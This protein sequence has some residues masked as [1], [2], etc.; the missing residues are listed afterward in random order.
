MNHAK[1]KDGR[2][3]AKM[4]HVMP[5][6]GW[7]KAGTP[8]GNKALHYS[9]L[10]YLGTQRDIRQPKREVLV[11]LGGNMER[12]LWTINGKKFS[13]SNPVHLKYGERVRL[14][15]VNNTMMAHPMHLHGMFLQLENGQSAGKLP[16]KHTVVIEPGQSLSALLTADEAGEWAFHCHLLYHALAGMF[17]KVVVSRPSANAQSIPIP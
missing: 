17:T 11:Q 10:R 7:S 6:S 5:T 2:K 1:D 15:F 12:Y 3:P 8:P 13:L 16:N 4:N 9:D 14:K